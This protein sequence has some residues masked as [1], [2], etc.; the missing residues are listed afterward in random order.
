MSKNFE[1][2]DY[3]PRRLIF[4]PT[5]LLFDR[6]GEFLCE[7]LSEFKLEDCF[8]IFSC[9]LSR[10]RMALDENERRRE[11]EL[12]QEQR[13]LS[14]SRMSLHQTERPNL[15]VNNTQQTESCDKNSNQSINGSAHAS[16]F[17]HDSLPRHRKAFVRNTANASHSVTTG[18]GSDP[19]VDGG[20]LELLTR[21]DIGQ[22]AENLLFAGGSFRRLGSGRRS[23]RNASATSN[24]FSSES[25]RERTD[26]NQTISEKTE[27][28][29]SPPS[30]T[31]TRSVNLYASGSL[32]RKGSTRRMATQLQLN[33][34][35]TTQ[36]S[37]SSTNRL[38]DS[39]DRFSRMRRSIRG[40]PLASPTG[41]K[42][43]LRTL[44]NNG[45]NNGG[46][47]S[48][49]GSSSSLSNT[50]HTFGSGLQRD[51]CSDRVQSSRDLASIGS[52]P[53]ATVSYGG[54][55]SNAGSSCNL[56]L[57]SR[58]ANSSHSSQLSIGTVI[59]AA[60]PTTTSN[61]GSNT[62]SNSCNDFIAMSGKATADNSLN[63]S[64]T[65]M[66]SNRSTSSSLQRHATFVGGSLLSGLKNSLAQLLPKDGKEKPPKSF[67]QVK[68]RVRTT[69]SNNSSSVAGAHLQNPP[70][71][72]TETKQLVAVKQRQPIKCDTNS[73]SQLDGQIRL[74]LQS[75]APAT[76]TTL[77]RT[78]LLRMSLNSR[79]NSN[80][81]QQSAD[82]P[83]CTS[84][85]SF[86]ASFGKK[87]VKNSSNC[88]DSV[89][90]KSR[91]LDKQPSRL[92]ANIG[93]NVTSTV[94]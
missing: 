43:A 71:K 24:A 83:E 6:T 81:Q 37:Q 72:Q 65:E 85:H 74:Q 12:R 60:A 49:G 9:F 47:N 75:L 33:C 55:G 18:D 59:A 87:S 82:Q 70:W 61:D 41:S 86:N 48:N 27:S 54:S 4:L 13:K 66:A 14:G 50:V 3:R 5:W 53:L 26:C 16:S 25:G 52:P 77:N 28:N 29:G 2:S 8:R 84:A 91:F 17:S 73:F 69:W 42:T 80:K 1:R 20:L 7:D 68:P 39:F 31:M 64:Q 40:S 21:P 35:Q 23:V 88:F 94:R 46:H 67:S 38:D 56:L 57:S 78:S 93:K 63:S 51:E 36:P 92:G 34:N 45:G 62:K 89:G 32:Q 10:L 76:R 79:L 15:S 90:R 19:L 22:S 30:D 44:L 11:T 58:L